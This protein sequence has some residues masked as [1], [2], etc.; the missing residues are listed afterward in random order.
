[1]LPSFLDVLKPAKIKFFPS[2]RERGDSDRGR[3]RQSERGGEGETERGGVKG[4]GEGQRK[5]IQG[6]QRLEHA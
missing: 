4:K 5:K 2:L 6:Q 1:M 3:E